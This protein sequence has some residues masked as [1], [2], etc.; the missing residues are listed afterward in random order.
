MIKYYII[1]V[2]NLSRGKFYLVRAFLDFDGRRLVRI[3]VPLV[4]VKYYTVILRVRKNGNVI[5]SVLEERLTGSLVYFYLG[6][7]SGNG[8]HCPVTR[9]YIDVAADF[10]GTAA[11]HNDF[12]YI[13]ISDIN[14]RQ[15]EPDE[16]RSAERL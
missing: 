6:S 13:G 2:Q 5:Q 14:G 4:N 7:G 3:G 8:T 1:N 9:L 15:F 11:P 16:S 10:F 12:L